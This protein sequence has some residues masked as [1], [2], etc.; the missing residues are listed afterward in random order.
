VET[1]S[2]NPHI[3]IIE[4][5]AYPEI[6]DALAKSAVQVLIENDCTYDRIT[7]PGVFEIPAAIKYAVKAMQIFD[8]EGRYHGFVALGCVVRGESGGYRQVREES[9]R[10]LRELA[11]EY[12]LAIGNGIVIAGDLDQAMAQAAADQGNHGGQAA[13]TCVDMMG[14]KQRFGLHLR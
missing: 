3:L 12:S 7:V 4:S 6:S 10:G 11:G 5:R 8:G 1:S 9:I 2:V 14:L 13:R